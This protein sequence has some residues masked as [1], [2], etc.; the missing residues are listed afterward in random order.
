[1]KINELTVSYV[2]EQ[3][4]RNYYGGGYKQNVTTSID[5]NGVGYE[6]YC[7]EISG[8]TATGYKVVAM[9]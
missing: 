6:W 9:Y 8:T 4:V 3:S 1:S 5:S 7:L 2:V